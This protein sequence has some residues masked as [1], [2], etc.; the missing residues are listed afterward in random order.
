MYSLLL[1]ALLE[2]VEVQKRATDVQQQAMAAME[3]R[4]SEA[5]AAQLAGMEVQIQMLQGQARQAGVRPMSPSHPVR[6]RHVLQKM[7]EADDVDT[8]LLVFE[9]TEE[10]GMTSTA[11]GR[12]TVPVILRRGSAGVHGYVCLCSSRLP[13]PEEGNPGESW[14]GHCRNSPVV[15]IVVMDRYI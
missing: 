14:L 3:A 8:Y 4:H 7:T 10:R 5:M 15:E 11:M 1:Q 12:N 6:D 2:A 9:R 13:C